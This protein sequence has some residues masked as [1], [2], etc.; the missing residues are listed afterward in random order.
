MANKPLSKLEQ[1][2]LERIKADPVL[3]ARAYL[4]AYDPALGKFTPWV[5]RWYQAE[6]LRDQESKK[7]VCKYAF[8]M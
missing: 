8:G 7:K 1:E 2:Q 5:A 6:M 4:R 3:W